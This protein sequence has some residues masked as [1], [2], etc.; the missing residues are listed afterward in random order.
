MAFLGWS[1]L[2]LVFVD[3]VLAIAAA[4]DWG[5]HQGG[6]WL[7]VGAGLLTVL[8]WY[9]FA[10]PRARLGGRYVRPATKVLVF[11]LATAGLWAS[12]HHALALAFLAFSVVVNALTQLSSVQALIRD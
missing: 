3:E 1:V 2:F 4:V 6:G 11:S 8:V 12:G 10:S 9:V 5:T 7:G